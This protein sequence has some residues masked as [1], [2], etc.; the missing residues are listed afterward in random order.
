MIPVIITICLALQALTIIAA[1]W[2]VAVGPT[3]MDRMLAFD[4]ITVCGV[5]IIVILSFA[6]KSELFTDLVL[7]YSLVGFLGTVALTHFLYKTIIP[8]LSDHKPSG[9]EW[10]HD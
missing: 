4:L 3:V 5:G 6:W 9:K 1:L 8:R 7:V 10:H 2:R